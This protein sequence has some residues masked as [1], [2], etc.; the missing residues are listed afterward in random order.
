[1]TLTK[2][3]ENSKT[4]SDNF[5]GQLIQSNFASKYD[6][7]KPQFSIQIINFNALGV[8]PENVQQILPLLEPCKY[9]KDV[10][11]FCLNV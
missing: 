8:A 10:D 11:A 3:T 9:M 5:A 4:A 2:Q 1:M 7:G 6:M